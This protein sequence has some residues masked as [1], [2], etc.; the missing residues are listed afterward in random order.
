MISYNDYKLI[1]SR[2][3]SIMDYGFIKYN[4]CSRFL[5]GLFMGLLMSG[6]RVWYLMCFVLIEER[7]NNF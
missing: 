1:F 2:I 3:A 4:V 5:V 6:E 7:T